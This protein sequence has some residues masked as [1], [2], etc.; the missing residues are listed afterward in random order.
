MKVFYILFSLTLLVTT[1]AKSQARGSVP[2]TEIKIVKFY[3]NPAI[4]FITFEEIEKSSGKSYSL[5]IF[6]FLGK[7]VYESPVNSKTNIDLT[8][9]LRGLYI[10]QLKDQTGRISDSGKFQVNK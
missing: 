5:Q 10:F 3:P 4:S 6:N 9:F 2:E 1:Q 8:N 7:K